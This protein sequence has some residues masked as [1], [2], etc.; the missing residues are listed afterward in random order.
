MIT[1]E[2]LTED[3]T[4]TAGTDYRRSKGRVRFSPG[5]THQRIEIPLIDDDVAEP[6]ESIRLLLHADGRATMDA[7]ELMLTIVDDD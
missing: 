7:P 1:V 5:E 2:Y 3:G 6:D 4:A